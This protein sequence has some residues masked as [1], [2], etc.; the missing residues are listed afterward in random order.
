MDNTFKKIISNILENTKITIDKTGVN[1]KNGNLDITIPPNGFTPEDSVP[2]IESCSGRRREYICRGVASSGS[3][4]LIGGLY[5]AVV[6][7]KENV[8]IIPHDNLWEILRNMD[9]YHT[10]DSCGNRI[11]ILNDESIL[12]IYS[13]IQCELYNDYVLKYGTSTDIIKYYWDKS[14]SET[15]KSMVKMLA[16]DNDAGYIVE[17]VSNIL[18]RF[19][20]TKQ[21]DFSVSEDIRWEDVLVDICL[22]DRADQFSSIGYD[23]MVEEGL[24]YSPSVPGMMNLTFLKKHKSFFDNQD[25]LKRYVKLD[26]MEE[27]LKQE[28]CK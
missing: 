23:I 7:T 18:S 8:K 6:C 2:K 13:T 10:V 22:F 27:G 17:Y 14:I 20:Y 3:Y 24:T 1:V 28:G 11:K 12:V 5:F 15:V 19:K 26:L 9:S 25:N 16:N 4:D 21:N